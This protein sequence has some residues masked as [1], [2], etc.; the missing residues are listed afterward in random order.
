MYLGGFKSK[1]EAEI[2]RKA[3]ERVLGFTGTDRAPR[4]HK[5]HALSK[6]EGRK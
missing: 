2:A 3:A 1:R 6:W 4:D 5:E